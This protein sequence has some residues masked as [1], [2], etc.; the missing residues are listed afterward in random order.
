MELQQML[1]LNCLLCIVVIHLNTNSFVMLIKQSISLCLL[2]CLSCI[3]SFSNCTIYIY[4][5]DMWGH[6]FIWQVLPVTSCLLASLTLPSHSSACSTHCILQKFSVHDE[7][8]AL[9]LNTCQIT[10]W[11]MPWTS[12][13]WDM[14]L[15]DW[16]IRSWCFEVMDCL[17][18][19]GNLSY[20]TVE[21]PLSACASFQQV[22]VTDDDCVHC[23][24]SVFGDRMISRWLW[25]PCPLDLNLCDRAYLRKKV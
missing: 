10:R 15:C 5:C 3:T 9:I 14:A 19:N 13:F 12:L 7:S 1:K 11:P 20:T 22:S 16:I 8:H 6:Y 18:K 23:L 2:F 24:E 21:T 17:E 4:W 25:P